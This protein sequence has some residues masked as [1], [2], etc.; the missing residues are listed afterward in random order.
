MAGTAPDGTTWAP[1][2]EVTKAAYRRR[3]DKVDDRPL[4]DPN[5]ILNRQIFHR[6][7]ANS[8][9]WG[10]NRNYA[11]VMQFG[12]TKGKFGRSSHGGPIPWGTSPPAR[13]SAC[14]PR[15]RRPSWTNWSNGWR[16]QPPAPTPTGHN[17]MIPLDPTRKR[18]KPYVTADQTI[19]HYTPTPARD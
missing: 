18:I 11:G 4:F 5:D 6:A 9:S 15:T 10:S 7:D 14:R 19:W 2:S 12:A 17:R 3:G 1:K 16:A 8:V 13:S